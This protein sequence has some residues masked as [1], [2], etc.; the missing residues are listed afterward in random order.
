MRVLRK[1]KLQI[2]WQ[3]LVAPFFVSKFNSYED[4]CLSRIVSRHKVIG[5]NKAE[6]SNPTHLLQ[7]RC[8]N[9]SNC[10]W[11]YFL[12]LLLI[13]LTNCSEGNSSRH[14]LNYLFLSKIRNLFPIS[15]FIITVFLFQSFLIISRCL[16]GTLICK[17][18]SHFCFY[19]VK[20]TFWQGLDI[21]EQ[22]LIKVFKLGVNQFSFCIRWTMLF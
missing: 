12:I 1:D 11:H 19:L 18:V 22:I 5:F 13:N 4:F 7:Q 10:N 8:L 16:N 15:Y 21:L 17:Y 6:E 2:I 20:L 3:I 14:F 9:V